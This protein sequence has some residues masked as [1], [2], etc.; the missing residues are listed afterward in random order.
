MEVF[1]AQVINGVSLGSIY[2]LLATGFNLLLLVA[3]IIPFSYPQVVVFSMY[4]TW[5]V[6][7]A[8][9]NNLLLGVAAAI[10]SSILFNVISAPIFQK[11]MQKRGAVDINTAALTLNAALTTTAGGAVTVTH[12]GLADLNAQITA[13]GPLIVI[14]VVISSTGMPSKRSSMSARE[15]TATPHLPNSPRAWGE[16][17]SYP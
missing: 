7:Q 2:V 11:I 17:E 3:M 4:I 5:L 10:A 6:L 9:G 12:T 13:A 1:V 14:E 8:T 15:L 16:S